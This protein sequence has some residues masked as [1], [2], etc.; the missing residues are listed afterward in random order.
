[1]VD[2]V[3]ALVDVTWRSTHDS[4]DLP[5]TEEYRVAGE[6]VASRFKVSEQ[7]VP[8]GENCSAEFAARIF[9]RQIDEP[10]DTITPAFGA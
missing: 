2:L 3:R 7:G 5:A 9:S 8:A 1:M 4:W 10:G 6:D